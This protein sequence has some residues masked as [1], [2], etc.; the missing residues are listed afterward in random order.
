ML[1]GPWCSGCGQG[2]LEEG[3][4]GSPP[5]DSEGRLQFGL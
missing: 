2:G 4:T 3:A 5:G 1:E